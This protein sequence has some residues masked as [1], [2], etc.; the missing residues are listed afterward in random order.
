MLFCASLRYNIDPF[1]EYNDSD[2][3]SALEQASDQH[4]KYPL[5]VSNRKVRLVYARIEIYKQMLSV[6]KRLTLS[7]FYFQHTSYHII[8]LW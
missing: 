6:C 7:T 1:E 2:L 3:W 4:F 8:S 5:I